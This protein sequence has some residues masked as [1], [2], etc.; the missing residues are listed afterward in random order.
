MT[1]FLFG[2]ALWSAVAPN[3]GK[4]T[5]DQAIQIATENSFSVKIS[6]SNVAKTRERI[7]EVR[8]AA[9]PKLNLQGTYTRFD[10]ATTANFGGNNVTISP[11]DSKQAVLS[12]SYPLDIFGVIG[13]TISAA[14]NAETA[15][16]YNREAVKSDLKLSVRSA[17]FT[18][19]QADAQVEV[20]KEALTRAQDQL[21]NTRL[22]FEQGAK[23]KVDVLRFETQYAQAQADLIAAQN[24]LQLAKSAF[25][26]TLGRPIETEF[27]LEKVDQS[28]EP[29]FS[30]DGLVETSLSNRPEIKALQHQIRALG[31]AKRA[32]EGGLKPSLAISANHTRNL[33]AQGLSARDYST[34]GTLALSI[35]LFDSGLTRARVGQAREDETQA[36]IQLE[37][38]KLGISLE[39][40]QAVT[41]LMN[42]KARIAVA[43]NQ[44]KFAQ[45][46]YDIAVLRDKVGEGIALQVVDAQ[47][48]LTRARNGLISARYDYL[49]AYAALQRAVGTDRFTK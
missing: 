21:K 28:E 13:K 9:G 7:N 29:A 23:A 40:R 36:R 37:Q 24:G 4:L 17:Y 35:P 31:E 6:D 11:I 25:N 43:E 3:Q 26:N 1:M 46:S 33:D 8:S 44:V 41:N 47:T 39:V 15:Q 14:R 30:P 5:L 32:A 16:S 34:T 2:A 19:L 27:D 18:V 38:V 42:A 22:E 20:A 48:E 45:E 10:K 12:L 49:K